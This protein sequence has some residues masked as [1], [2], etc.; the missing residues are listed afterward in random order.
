MSTEEILE[1]PNVE[2]QIKLVAETLK[3]Q[4]PKAWGLSIAQTVTLSESEVFC[5]RNS[6]L[7][8]I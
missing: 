1:E 7:L 6:T 2:Q 8:G 3:V 4:T 5:S